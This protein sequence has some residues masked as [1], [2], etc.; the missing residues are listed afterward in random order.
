[1][2]YTYL[3]FPPTISFIT[4]DQKKY[5]KIQF[6]WSND[7]ILITKQI[8]L[9]KYWKNRKCALSLLFLYHISQ[10][11]ISICIKSLFH[12]RRIFIN[13][14]NILVY[15]YKIKKEDFFS[16][17]FANPTVPNCTRTK[18]TRAVSC[19]WKLTIERSFARN[20]KIG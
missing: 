6:W 4:N 9:S 17:A 19:L 10:F 5:Q 14:S 2:Y 20:D 3:I 16:K 7:F 1:M 15:R 12:L 11:E 18:F 13:V 8:V